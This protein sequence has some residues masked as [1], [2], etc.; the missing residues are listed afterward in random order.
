MFKALFNVL[1]SV[2]TG[3]VNIVLAPINLLA[4]TLLP[5]FTEMI[6]TWYHVLNNI[7]G[8]GFTYFF[9]IL[10]PHCRGVIVLYLTFLI[11]FYTVS[12]SA[13]AILKVYTIIKNMKIW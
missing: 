3:L 4:A 6:A 5:D 8:N 7:I 11:S 12:I 2:I 9:S 10:P 13:H 1:F